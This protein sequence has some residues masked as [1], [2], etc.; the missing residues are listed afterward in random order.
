MRIMV[1]HNAYLQ[2]GGEDLVVQDEVSLLEKNGHQVYL[3]YRDNREIAQLGRARVL[4]DT[5]W[6]SRTATDLAAAF[7]AFKPHVLHVH[8]T[9][10]LISPSIYWAAA[11]AG[12]PVVQ[13][14][15]NFRLLCVQAMFL[16]ECRVCE[17]CLGRLPWRG[18]VRKCYRQSRAASAAVAGMLAIHRGMGTFSR[19]V[20]RYI[21]LNDFCKRKLVEGGLPA[22]RI[23]IKPNFVDWDQ[24]RDVV[25]GSR[26]LY[27]GRLSPEKGIATLAEAVRLAPEIEVDVV[28]DGPDASL[29]TGLT[30]VR[31]H[32]FCDSE[33]IRRLMGQARALVLPSICYE[34][35]PRGVVE[36][37]ASGLPTI[38]SRLGVM[39]EI[40]QDGV[41]GMLF[42]AGSARDLACRLRSMA[43]EATAADRMGKRARLEYEEKYTPAANHAKL[44]AIYGAVLEERRRG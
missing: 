6:A 37:F 8:N 25:R 29:L 19:K 28:G 26:F 40:V 42:E 16:R 34:S 38:A 2:R 35:F 23:S 3:Y 18:A 32:G 13:T 7:Q 21:A 24:R 1:A 39:Q 20:S 30:N 10:P 22:D 44:M 14:L 41:T 31:L 15:H 33:T 12:L 27:V 5:L 43:A 17:D 4:A 9:F 36:A 11:R